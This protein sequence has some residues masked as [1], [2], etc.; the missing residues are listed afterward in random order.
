MDGIGG[1]DRREGRRGRREHD[2][3]RTVSA[4]RG[5][6]Q[7]EMRAL[8]KSEWNKSCGEENGQQPSHVN[9]YKSHF[10]S[11]QWQVMRNPQN[12]PGAAP[13]GDA[14]LLGVSRVR[15]APGRGGLAPAGRFGSH[16]SMTS[17][18]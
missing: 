7:V 1:W 8:K 6:I 17:S 10:E 15:T 2:T 4:P 3:E 16:V 13:S 11:S 18:F 12:E 5:R 14:K 9:K